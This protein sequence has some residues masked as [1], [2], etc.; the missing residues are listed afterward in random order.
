[1]TW[2]MHRGRG[3]QSTQQST[4]HW[5]VGSEAMP[6]SISVLKTT[7]LGHATRGRGDAVQTEGAQGLVV[8]GKLALTL[9][10]GKSAM[11][12]CVRSSAMGTCVR[13]DDTVGREEGVE[14]RA[15]QQDRR[16]LAGMDVQCSISTKRHWSILLQSHLVGIIERTSKHQR[17]HD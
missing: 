5:K 13:S 12:T 14:Q 15:D 8:A 17:P 11:G 4:H 7:D 9:W 16:H 1:M 3:M 2:G 10:Q 6:K